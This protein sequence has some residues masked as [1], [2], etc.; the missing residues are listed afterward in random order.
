MLEIIQH[1]LESIFLVELGRNFASQMASQKTRESRGVE[2]WSRSKDIEIR[3]N[4][5]ISWIEGSSLDS[6]Q[7]LEPYCIVGGAN[8]S[9]VNERIV[10]GK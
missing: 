10:T 5:Q 6:A 7:H 2:C 4:R 8:L 3:P 9:V 1:Y